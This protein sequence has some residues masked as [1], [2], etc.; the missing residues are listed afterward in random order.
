MLLNNQQVLRF[1]TNK[2]ILWSFLLNCFSLNCFLCKEICQF[3][4]FSFSFCFFGRILIFLTD[5][6]PR[7]FF[8]SKDYYMI[9]LFFFWFKLFWL[10]FIL[11]LKHSFFGYCTNFPLVGIT[12]RR[13]SLF[14]WLPSSTL[15][16]LKM[17]L[18]KI[19]DISLLQFSFLL[20]PLFQQILFPNFF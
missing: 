9:L 11:I 3:R 20:I 17:I 18:W 19:E 10:S 4:C 7:Y 6:S 16:V 5:C 14:Y 2:V 8:Q 15:L 12:I 13:F 1:Q